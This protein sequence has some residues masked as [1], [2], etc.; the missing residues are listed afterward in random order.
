LSYTKSEQDHQLVLY[1]IQK[2]DKLFFCIILLKDSS[3]SFKEIDT[4]NSR[5]FSM[6][7]T[8]EKECVEYATKKANEFIES[9]DDNL[10]YEGKFALNIL[11][12]RSYEV[13]SVKDYGK[14]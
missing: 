9:N 7:L 2:Q 14:L 4:D 12:K 10:Q 8:S 1:M 13:R 3:I 6:P 5:V 11:E